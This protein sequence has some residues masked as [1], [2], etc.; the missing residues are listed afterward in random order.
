M[1]KRKKTTLKQAK[2]DM[3]ALVQELRGVVARGAV[4]GRRLPLLEEELQATQ[5]YL[6][7]NCS[8]E[9]VRYDEDEKTPED[10]EQEIK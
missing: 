5:R 4:S 6:R 2:I 10:L 9:A 1:D 8:Y 3:D 7:T